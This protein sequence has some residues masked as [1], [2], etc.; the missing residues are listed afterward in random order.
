MKIESIVTNFSYKTTGKTIGECSMQEIRKDMAE[1]IQS[2]WDS[3]TD[4]SWSI[5]NQHDIYH[6]EQAIE[7]LKTITDE[8]ITAIITGKT[9]SG[10]ITEASL[11]NFSGWEWCYRI[12]EFNTP[13]L[14]TA[15]YD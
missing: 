12:S 1:K 4:E 14:S 10:D 5:N 15:W 6:Y 3:K 9:G 2:W 7:R 8:E 11:E 13:E